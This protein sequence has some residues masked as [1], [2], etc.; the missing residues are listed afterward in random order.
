M[1][2]RFTLTLTLSLKGEGIYRWTLVKNNNMTISIQD[3]GFYA[4]PARRP[5]TR[6]AGQAG[7]TLITPF[8]GVLRIFVGS[9]SVPTL[10]EGHSS[11]L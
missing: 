9:G 3:I 2:R 1:S 11:E 7:P 8:P 10:S 6:P 5:R 4:R